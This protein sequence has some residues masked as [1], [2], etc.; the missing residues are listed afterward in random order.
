M[1]QHAN[2]TELSH[3][4]YFQVYILKKAQASTAASKSSIGTALVETISIFTKSPLS[5]HTVAA[6]NRTLVID[7]VHARF[8]DHVRSNG[9]NACLKFSQ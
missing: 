8:T 9:I 5:L 4:N 3:F 6:H 2:I 7:I 1:R